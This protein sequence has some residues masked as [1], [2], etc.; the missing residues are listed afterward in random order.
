MSIS[1]YHQ[2]MRDV[3]D[4]TVLSCKYAILAVERQKNDLERQKGRDFPYFFDEKHADKMLALVGLMRHTKGKW[5]D[6]PF[7]LQPNQAFRLACVFGWLRKDDGMRRF[8][9][10]YV[11]VARKNGKSEESA[12]IMLL[13]LLTE[14]GAPEVYSAATTKDQASISFRAAKA[15]AK[16]LKKDSPSINKIIHA[17]L[18]SVVNLDTD[19]FIKAL[20]S[21][22]D[23]LDGASPDTAIIDEYHA[24]KTSDV[25]DVLESGMGSREQP[26][27]YII[28]TAGFNLESPCY[29]L[30]RQAIQILQG[31]LVDDTFFSIIYTI[32]EEDDWKDKRFWIK[33]NPSLGRTPLINSMESL[34]T[35]AMNGGESAANGFKTKNLNVWVR[36]TKGWVKD[37]VWMSA[38]RQKADMTGRIA[39]GG[40]DLA[41]TADFSALSLFFPAIDGEEAHHLK[42]WFWLPEDAFEKRAVLFPIFREWLA[43][44][45]IHLCP[46]AVMDYGLI[47]RTVKQ[48]M[49]DYDIRVIGIDP[50]NAF[51][52]RV[53]LEGDGVPMQVFS[54]GIMHMSHPTKE[55]ERLVN[56]GRIDHDENPVARWMVGNV[57]VWRD[58]NDNIKLHKAKSTEK[59]DGVVA[60]VIA[61]GE[62]L[63]LPPSSSSYLLADGA[64][65]MVF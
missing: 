55:L 52:L 13:T 20:A 59:I 3:L 15:M 39:Y 49:A 47:E 29:T 40:I 27:L 41:S 17:Y 64:E 57:E 62:Y 61:L 19:G 25:L 46:G 23:T 14:P 45:Y 42:W 35:K 8:R 32:D 33:A 4:G 30:R 48:A 43:D 58:A 9:R 22:A 50:A 6:K 56:L 34:F 2:Y 65:L 31:I 51:Q 16:N 12:A 21:D 54:Q 38:P 26:L 7:D 37:E 44:G 18:Y 60:S 36:S 53:K 63:T 28:T 5:K 11:E 1:L 24:H 10:A